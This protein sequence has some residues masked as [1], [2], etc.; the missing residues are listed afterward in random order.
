MFFFPTIAY[1]GG[2][3]GLCCSVLLFCTLFLVKLFELDTVQYR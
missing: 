2:P 1:F 3:R